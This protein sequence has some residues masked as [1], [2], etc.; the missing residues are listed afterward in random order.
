MRELPEAERDDLTPISEELY[1]SLS[2]TLAWVA[3][4]NL[5]AI[6][7][8]RKTENSPAA[9]LAVWQ[10]INGSGPSATNLEDA[11]DTLSRAMCVG[12]TAFATRQ[13]RQ[14]VA[15]IELSEPGLVFPPADAPGSP[16]NYRVEIQNRRAVLVPVRRADLHSWLEWGD[17]QF[18]RERVQETFAAVSKDAAPVPT[19]NSATP[20]PQV[21]QA[22][23]EDWFR[24]VVTEVSTG[25]RQQP[26]Q[27]E[28]YKRQR[29]ASWSRY[30]RPHK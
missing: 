24:K 28:F 5:A 2:D 12:L 20:I 22:A 7:R 16:L 1:W 10:S 17:L 14:A 3:T 8:I 27:K 6:A 30:A 13:Q 21:S 23:L 29:G 18:S 26:S 11:R 15:G 19:S 9:A 4:R 25:A